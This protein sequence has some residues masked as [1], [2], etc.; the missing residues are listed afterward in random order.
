MRLLL[1]GMLRK[2]L[3]DCLTRKPGR[4]NRVELVAQHAHD[5]GRH[6]VVEK[7]NGVLDLAM[8]VLRDS[9]LVQ[10]AARALSNLLDIA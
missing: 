8:I 3:F 6:G 9:A 4:G 1:F 7:G 10:M 2:F 5:L